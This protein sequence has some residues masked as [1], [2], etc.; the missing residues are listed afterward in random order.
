MTPAADITEVPVI[1]RFAPSPTGPLHLG[2]LVAALGSYVMAHRSGG[3][4]L[5]R[6]EDL[7]APRVVSGIA[8]DILR[9]LES[10]GFRWDGEVVYQ[11]RRTEAYRS[12]MEQLLGAGLAYSCGCTRSEIARISSAPHGAELVYPGICRNGLPEGKSERA[13]RV[14]VYD[15]LI[16]FNDL[17]VGHYSQSLS[18]SCGDFVIQRADGPFAYHLAVVVDDGESGVNQV[19]RGADLLQSTPRQIYLQKLLG[20]PVPVYGHLPLVVNP[21]GT[22][23]SK[24]ENAVSLADRDLAR[25]GWRLLFAA[26]RFL[27]QS[28]PPDLNGAPCTEILAW[29]VEAFDPASVPSTAAPLPLPTGADELPSRR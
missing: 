2:S 4:W 19:V 26:L 24:R 14:K 11:S 10:L 16:E 6:M 13:W 9:T 27:G 21:D 5:L 22:K 1:G 20:F 17:F 23:L 29:G 25:E 18:S 8:D 7:D 3:K 12:A 15:E 28:P